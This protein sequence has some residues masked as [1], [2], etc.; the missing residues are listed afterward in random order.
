MP[1]PAGHGGLRARAISAARWTTIWVAA[2]KGLHVVT[3]VVLARTLA[4]AE[5][6]AMALL[7]VLVTA[8]ALCQEFGTGAG[9]IYRREDEEQTAGFVLSFQVI[10]GILLILLAFAAADPVARFFGNPVLAPALRVLSLSYLLAPFAGVPLARLEKALDYRGKVLV[11]LGGAAAQTLVV[12]ALALA[13][14]GLWS[15]VWGM[16]AGKLVSAGLVWLGWRRPVS[17]AFTARL[18]RQTLAYS[19]YIFGELMLWFVSVNVDDLIVGR[20]LG[21]SALGVYK[22]GFSTAVM[23]AN[24]VGALTR[25][26]FPAFAR[27]RD[28]LPL[29]RRAFLRSTEYCVMIGT[30][31]FAL[32]G[33]LAQ[34]LVVTVY[35]ERWSAAAPVLQVLAPYAVLWVAA[36]MV[37]DLF[38]ACGAVRAL[39]W[40]NAGRAVVL[41]GALLPVARW[42]VMGVA[43]AVLGVAVATR[44]VQFYV[45][46]R[47]LGLAIADYQATFG[48]TLAATGVMTVAVMAAR[49]ALPALPPA[50][51]LVLHAALGGGL[52]LATAAWLSRAR[53]VELFGLLRTAA[54]LG[55]QG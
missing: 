55:R 51:D 42:G 53:V 25:V 26:A 8:G 9:L 34:P 28:D 50:L 3:T 52:Y 41:V 32:L 2:N 20:L 38:K 23:P 27:I 1:A 14:L 39:F 18:A 6:G 49:A 19:R 29:L 43:L 45:V 4:Q 17:L 35:G 5:F 33:I 21:T 48:P 30:P 22:V 10:A 24:S 40:I 31:V 46:S 12:V 37:A 15:F 11:D 54:A 47:V 36:T 13:G 44:A 7:T 16:L